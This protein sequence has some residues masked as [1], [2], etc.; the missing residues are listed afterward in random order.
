MYCE[1]CGQKINEEK[2]CQNCGHSN[3]NNSENYLQTTSKWIGKWWKIGVIILAVIILISLL[4]LPISNVKT[5][6]NNSQSVVNILCD[7]GSGGSGTI[8]SEDG[9]VLTNYHVIDGT[10]SC[11]V[12]IPDIISGQPLEIYEATPIVVPKLSKEYDIASLTINAPYKDEDG[13][14]WGTYTKKFPNFLLPETCDISTPSKLG[15]SVIIYGYPITSGGN[16]LTITSGIISSFADDG[17]IFT[18]AQ[19]D[20][21][22]SG[23]LAIDQ[24]GCWLG[25]PS[26]VISGDY[27]NLGVIISSSIIQEFIDGSEKLESDSYSVNTENISEEK[28]IAPSKPKT[29]IPKNETMQDYITCGNYTWYAKDLGANSLCNEGYKPTCNTSGGYYCQLNN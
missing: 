11:F 14:I 5:E 12:T 20:S 22:N 25:I 29:S 2:F 15:D 27:Q 1:N 4:N 21:G 9:V 3:I 26:A 18:T 17:S 6:I 16:N 10:K 23:G 28:V 19:I 8:I 7:N 24:D 13:K